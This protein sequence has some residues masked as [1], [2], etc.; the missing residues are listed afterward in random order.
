MGPQSIRWTAL[1]PDRSEN[2]VKPEVDGN[3]E[4]IENP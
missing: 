3:E 4:P 1:I 2:R